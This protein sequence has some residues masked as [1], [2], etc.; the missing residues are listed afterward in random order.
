M[1]Q[2]RVTAAMF[3]DQHPGVDDA[4]MDTQ[5]LAAIKKLAGI[6]SFL[7]REDFYTAGGHDPALTTPNDSDAHT[8]SPVGSNI[9]Q[10]GMEKKRL[11]RENNIKPGSP[12][13]FQLWR[14]LP[15]LTGEKPVGDELAPRVKNKD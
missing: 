8:M 5:D 1:K 10:T 14:S 11:E 3:S 9:S 7:I 15:Y 2:I 13:W 6:P 4:V 12:E